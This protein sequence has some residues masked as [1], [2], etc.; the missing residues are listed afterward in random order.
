[1]VVIHLVNRC[2]KA[3]TAGNFPL[4]AIG[5][6][7]MVREAPAITGTPTS[8]ESAT[9]IE[10]MTFSARAFFIESWVPIECEEE[11]IKIELLLQE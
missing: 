5:Y 4:R 9:K 10:E 2:K 3:R 11:L 8:C 7:I 6:A 1:M